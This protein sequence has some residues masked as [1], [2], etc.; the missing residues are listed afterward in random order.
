VSGTGAVKA[1]TDA[2][3]LC[4]TYVPAWLATP[5]MGA[6]KIAQ[7]YADPEKR[8]TDAQSLRTSLSAKRLTLGKGLWQV[9]RWGYYAGARARH[10]MRHGTLGSVPAETQVRVSAATR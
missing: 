9:V 6:D 5:G 4:N 8:R 10:V 1:L 3:R 2:E 7:Y